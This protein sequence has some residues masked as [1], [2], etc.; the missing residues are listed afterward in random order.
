MF[1]FSTTGSSFDFHFSQ[2][3]GSTQNTERNASL[4]PGN[5][6]RGCHSTPSLNE[7]VRGGSVCDREAHACTSQHSRENLRG[8]SS[9]KELMGSGLKVP[10]FSPCLQPP[11]PP[12]HLESYFFKKEWMVSTAKERVARGREE[13]SIQQHPLP[14]CPLSRTDLPPPLTTL[15]PRLWALWST[16]RPWHSCPEEASA[17]APSTST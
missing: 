6:V 13:E 12:V 9:G 1:S 2:Q 4:N 17:Q 8:I 7:V 11:P 15:A 10:I 3:A 16:P 5:N 14:L